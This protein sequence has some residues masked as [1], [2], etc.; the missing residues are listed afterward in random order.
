MVYTP[1]RKSDF[2]NGFKNIFVLADDLSARGLD[3]NDQIAS[4]IKV[5]NYE[6]FVALT[7]NTDKTM[8]WF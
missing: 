3:L 2:T 4:N 8:S 7:L 6:Q 5:I 1:F